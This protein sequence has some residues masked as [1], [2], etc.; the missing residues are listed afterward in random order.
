[1]CNGNRKL[2]ESLSNLWLRIPCSV[3][4]VSRNSDSSALS[5][6]LVFHFLMTSKLNPSFVAIIVIKMKSDSMFQ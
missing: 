5:I 2:F 4:T 3:K 1:M 6:D